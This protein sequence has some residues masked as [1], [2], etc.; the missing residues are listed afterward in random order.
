MHLSSTAN[1]IATLDHSVNV[2]SL[3]Y[4]YYYINRIQVSSL[5]I[6]WSKLNH[7]CKKKLVRCCLF[8]V[9]YC[10]VMNS[11][12]ENVPLSPFNSEIAWEL[13][14]VEKKYITRLHY[15]NLVI[16]NLCSRHYRFLSHLQNDICTTIFWEISIFAADCWLWEISCIRKENS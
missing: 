1:S 9:S 12:K 5:D 6:D 15:K 10:S 4:H 14:C 16:V 13:S 11:L 2:L 3:Y 8:S 7:L